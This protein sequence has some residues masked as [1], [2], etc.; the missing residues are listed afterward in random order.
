MIQRYVETRRAYEW[1][2]VCQALAGGMRHVL[3]DWELMV[4]QLEH[5]LRAGKLT[6]QVSRKRRERGRGGAGGGARARVGG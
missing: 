1:G 2:L 6:L 3:Q 5:Q 4:A